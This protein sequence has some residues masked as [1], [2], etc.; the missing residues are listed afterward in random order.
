M[1]FWGT[2]ILSV[3]VRIDFTVSTEPNQTTRIRLKQMT[4]CGGED[5]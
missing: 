4:V 2:N 5:C 1:M 3:S